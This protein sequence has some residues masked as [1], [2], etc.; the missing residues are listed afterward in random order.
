VSSDPRRAPT[1]LLSAS[2]V[3]LGVLIVARTVDAGGGAASVGVLLGVL[4]ALA[5][6]G[7]L[8]ISRERR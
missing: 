7:R 1:M 8:W 2:L 4:F 6:A 5:G 3:V